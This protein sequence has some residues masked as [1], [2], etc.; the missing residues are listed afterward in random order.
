MTHLRR[1]TTL[2][3]IINL[4]E[5]AQSERAPS[6]TFVERFARV[7]T[8]AVVVPGG[9]RRRRAAA[10]VRR[11]VAGW[12]YRALVLLVISCPC[13]LV[14]S[15]PVSIVSALAGAARKGVLIKGGR[16]L[17]TLGRVSVRGLRQDRHADARH[18]GGRRRVARSRRG[19]APTCCGWPPR[20]KAVRSIPSAAPSGARR[21]T[22]ASSWRRATRYQAL[23]GR[24]ASAE[25]DGVPAVIGNH[26]LFEER[27]WYSAAVD[28]AAAGL[29]RRRPHG[30]AGGVPAARHRRHRRR[31]R[32]APDRPRGD[33]PAAARGHP[34]HRHADRRPCEHGGAHRRG[35][36]A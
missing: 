36:R 4:V 13:A 2:A 28:A 26:R 19:R 15:T 23:P 20:S 16:H 32:R 27:G 17:E 22:K 3:R 7:Y 8:P 18:A 35:D 33:R 12:V 30:R 6:Q 25:V 10:G 29:D 11:T 24:G 5:H 14:I 31:R 21:A 1:D 34:A 9:R